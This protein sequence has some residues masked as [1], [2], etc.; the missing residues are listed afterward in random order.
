LAFESGAAFAPRAYRTGVI[1]DFG[2]HVIDFYHYLLVPD[3]DVTSAVHDGFHGP[4]G[5]AR[6]EI[7]ASGRADSPSASV[8]ITSSRTRRGYRLNEPK[9]GRMSTA[10]TPTGLRRADGRL[11]LSGTAVRP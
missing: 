5:L 4:E 3:W 8:D 2:V 10:L 11:A 6:I 1:M 7:T 9:F